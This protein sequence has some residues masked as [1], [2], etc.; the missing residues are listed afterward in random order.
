VYLRTD[1]QRWEVEARIGGEGGRSTIQQC[2]GQASALILAGAW[3]GGPTVWR[4]MPR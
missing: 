3:C 1:G 4:E 2:P